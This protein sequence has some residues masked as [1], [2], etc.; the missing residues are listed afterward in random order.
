MRQRNNNCWIDMIPNTCW[1]F[2]LNWFILIIFFQMRLPCCMLNVFLN[3]RQFMCYSYW[4]IEN[5]CFLSGIPWLYKLRPLQN[6]NFRRSRIGIALYNNLVRWSM[7][8]LVSAADQA[9]YQAKKEGRNG[10]RYYPDNQWMPEGR[11]IDLPL[12]VARYWLLVENQ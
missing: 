11:G 7:V 2:L 12:L 5:R 6:G 9:L 1:V 4:L 8:E 3:L 10:V